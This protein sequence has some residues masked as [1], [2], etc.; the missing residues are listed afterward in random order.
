MKDKISRIAVI[1]A[2]MAGMTCAKRLSAAGVHVEV[3]E[4]SRGIGGRLNTR[5]GDDWQCDL[6]AQYFTASTPAFQVEVDHWIE[7]NAVL[8]WY[9]RLFIYDEEGLFR[10][11]GADTVRHVGVPKMNAMLG[12][13]DGNV[14]LHLNVQVNGLVLHDDA[15]YL[16]LGSAGPRVGPFDAVLCAV[17][18]PQAFPLVAPWSPELRQI[19][20]SVEMLP[21]WAA[22]AHYDEPVATDFDAVF[23][24]E[25]AL[26]WVAR[27]SSKPLRQGK[28]TWL[29]HASLGW[30]Q[31][32][33]ESDPEWVSSELAN[34]V[35]E[36]LGLRPVNCKA[37][38]W[39]YAD[40]AAPLH[41]GAAWDQSRGIGLCG[42]W[43]S[44]GKVEGAWTSGKQLAEQVL[45]S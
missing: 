11:T 33:L 35:Q 18:A 4:K 20:S 15:W 16:D 27:D 23:V 39:R 25:G 14:A 5:R 26:R 29:I 10:H 28:E 21:C 24:N 40:M 6:G 19:A 42:D 13:L 38:R 31:R 44:G 12:C 17:P 1:G 43:L 7:K 45:K 22:V 9:P 32:W 41:L 2:G 8:P 30:S 3:F 37:H 36:I 34:A